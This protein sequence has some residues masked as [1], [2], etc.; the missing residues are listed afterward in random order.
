MALGCRLS[1]QN[2]QMALLPHIRSQ[3]IPKQPWL[4]SANYKL[5]GQEVLERP[6][7]K[8]LNGWFLDALHESMLLSTEISG[9]RFLNT[10]GFA[11]HRAIS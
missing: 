5:V 3:F 7:E 2:S 6:T 8:F 10:R 1:N 4:C 11:T 9:H